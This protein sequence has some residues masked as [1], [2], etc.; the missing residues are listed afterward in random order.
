VLTG[1]SRE[2]RC[3]ECG[4]AVRESLPDA[5][6]PSP[7]AC[8]TK[9]G[10]KPG[11]YARTV[12]HVLRG[13]TFFR[14]LAVCSSLNTAVRFVVWIVL[15][16]AIL[17]AI[18]ATV[19]GA[20]FEGTPLETLTNIA[21][22]FAIATGIVVLVFS[23]GLALMALRACRLGWRDPRPTT[24]VV[25]YASVLFL[26]MVGTLGV[27]ALWMLLAHDAGLMRG[28]FPV[29]IFGWMDHAV[30][31]GLGLSV[32]PIAAFTWGLARLR[33]ALRDVRFASA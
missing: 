6:R 18:V 17:C 22:R 20:P 31:W 5:R 14:S 29:P 4:L 12:W 10:R 28:G 7:W 11:A 25:C 23:T 27:C 3:P 19:V 26:P 9:L 13:R 1:L 8:A 24:A 16:T 30:L 21:L 33:R 2:G 15:L 32:L